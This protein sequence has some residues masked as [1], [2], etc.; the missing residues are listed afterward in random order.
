MC[1]CMCI[2]VFLGKEERRKEQRQDRHTP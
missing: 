1:V 2:C